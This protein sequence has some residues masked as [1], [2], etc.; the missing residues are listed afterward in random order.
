[1]P[2]IFTAIEVGCVVPVQRK[3]LAVGTLGSIL[4]QA[5]ISIEKQEQDNQALFSLSPVLRQYVK[6]EYSREGK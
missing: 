1:M 6:N 4:N 3:T 5:G 2:R